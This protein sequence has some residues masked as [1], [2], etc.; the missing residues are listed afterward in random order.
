MDTSKKLIRL[1]GTTLEGGG[2][3]LRLA[4]SF[5]S[6]THIP[7][8]I[9]NIRGNRAHP[10]GKGT[11]GGLKGSHLAAVEWLAKATGAKTE[12]AEIKSRELVFEPGQFPSHV[13]SQQQQVTHGNSRSKKGKNDCG[14]ESVWRD[15]YEGSTLIQRRSEIASSTPGSIFLILQAVLPYL[16]F[17]TPLDLDQAPSELHTASNDKPV[18]LRIRITGGTNVDKSMS[19]EYVAQVLFPTLYKIGLPPISMHL[20]KRG[21]THGGNVIG[22]V[23]FDITPFPRGYILPAFSFYERG[24]VLKFY[25]SILA[26]SAS[27]RETIMN[28]V[29]ATLSKSYPDADT[30]FPISEDSHNPKRLYLHL[31]AETSNG[32][33]LGRDWMYNRKATSATPQQKLHQLVEKVVRDLQQELAHGGCVDEFMHDQ[34]VVFQALAEGRSSVYAGK[35][36]DAK[37]GS[38]HTQTVRWVTERVLGVKFEEDGSCE[39]VGFRVGERYWEREANREGSVIEGVEKLEIKM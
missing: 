12:G 6:L 35:R 22:S 31:A 20:E 11:G 39:G 3:L 9:F 24:H 2:Q 36:A 34:L 38:L 29:V 30:E 32:F 26:P 5:S 23:I 15:I 14:G 21:W 25:A 19:Y 7:L 18:P 28:D 33:R 1:D 27:D 10:S 8:Q 17:S 4:L 16:L 37:K 13:P